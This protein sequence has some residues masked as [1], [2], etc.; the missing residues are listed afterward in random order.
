[1]STAVHLVR[2]WPAAPVGSWVPMGRRVTR[3]VR[4]DYLL[5]R[6]LGKGIAFAASIS[7]S[8]DGP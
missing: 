2:R 3:V 7:C 1:M 4:E 6:L 5:R 8:C